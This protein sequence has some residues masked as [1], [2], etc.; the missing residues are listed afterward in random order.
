M[1]DIWS[2]LSHHVFVVPKPVC[3]GTTNTTPLFLFFRESQNSVKVEFRGPAAAPFAGFGITFWWF[4]GLG[5][6]KRQRDR[7]TH[8]KSQAKP[9]LPTTACTGR[10]SR[11]VEHRSE[12]LP[13]DRTLPARRDVTVHETKKAVL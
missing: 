2:M 11:P 12:V 5:Q 6:N 10:T 8:Q 3:F 13:A 1:G 4:F 9:T 7:Q